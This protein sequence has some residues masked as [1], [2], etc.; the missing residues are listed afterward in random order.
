MYNHIEIKVAQMATFA[1]PDGSGN[2]KATEAKF[3]SKN[4]LGDEQDLEL[5]VVGVPEDHPEMSAITLCRARLQVFKTRTFQKDMQT[6]NA[7]IASIAEEVAD[8]DGIKTPYWLNISSSETSVALL[9]ELCGERCLSCIMESL[10]GILNQLYPNGIEAIL[11]VPCWDCGA[12]GAYAAELA[13]WKPIKFKGLKT[14][15]VPRS[16]FEGAT[17]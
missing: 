10:P 1:V 13:G 2:M 14:Y 5:T 4:Q 11:Y 16:L 6:I 8:E 15:Y 9:T 7:T 12:D 3:G 17:G